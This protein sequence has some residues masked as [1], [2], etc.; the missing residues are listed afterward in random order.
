VCSSAIAR[1]ATRALRY[2]ESN[3]G[4]G[5][6]V[7][8]CTTNL[9]LIA[10]SPLFDEQAHHDWFLRVK[11][12]SHTEPDDVPLAIVPLTP[13]TPLPDDDP[14]SL[15]AQLVERALSEIVVAERRA[16]VATAR[17]GR[18]E[19]LATTDALTGIGNQRA[20]W[21]RIAEEEAHRA[22]TPRPCV[23]AVIDLDDLKTVNDEQGHLN[24]DL[25]LRLAAQTL[26]KTVRGFDVVA[27]V[28]GDEIAVLALDFE[29]DQRGFAERLATA[30]EAADIRASIGT[31]TPQPPMS[32]T[33]AYAEADKA[34]YETKRR[35]HSHSDNE[36]ASR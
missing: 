23:I 35:R 33:E 8:F 28:G 29:G 11:Q 15:A 10:T 3:Q 36:R 9:K 21:D 19:A 16:A 25:L 24:G 14:A 13:E 22:R 5:P 12:R 27:R 26:R 30:L 17:A 32:L 34:M 4:I 2:L 1:A 18:A 31:A 7:A 20:W 6:W